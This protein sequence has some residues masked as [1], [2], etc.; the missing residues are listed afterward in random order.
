MQRKWPARGYGPATAQLCAIHGE[1]D[2]VD[3]NERGRATALGDGEDRRLLVPDERLEPA[4]HQR[5]AVR[6]DAH[7]F[8]EL[9]IRDLIDVHRLD[10]L[11]RDHHILRHA[12][13]G[14]ERTIIQRDDV[15]GIKK[16]ARHARVADHPDVC[17]EAEINLGILPAHGAARSKIMRNFC[18]WCLPK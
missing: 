6:N 11:H 3:A 5:L 9:V 1:V 17:T 15:A 10:Q 4:N 7:R 12:D 14:L 16:N 13:G 2:L 18:H 8:H